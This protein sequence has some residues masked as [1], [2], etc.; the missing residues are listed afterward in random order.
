VTSSL[1]CV[2]VEIDDE[3]PKATAD[4]DEV[5]LTHPDRALTPEDWPARTLVEELLS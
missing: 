3:E 5:R 4:A 1:I 2:E